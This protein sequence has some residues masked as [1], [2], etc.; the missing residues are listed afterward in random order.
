MMSSVTVTNKWDRRFLSA[1]ECIAQWSP[2]PS[3]KIGAVAVSQENLP[4]SWGWNAF[5]RKI[6]SIKEDKVDRP[7]KYKYVIHAEANVIYNAT[8]GNI[9]LRDSKLYI[10]GIPPCLDCAKA[11][12]QVGI[13]R[14]TSIA[15]RETNES[16][17]KSYEESLQLF[18]E[19][20]IVSQVIYEREDTSK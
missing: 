6:V 5:P 15:R 7:T 10:Y 4:L 11:I 1:A 17:L 14:V 16:W 19:V 8:R 12:I 18:R 3:S 2:D 20:G 9:S 13:V